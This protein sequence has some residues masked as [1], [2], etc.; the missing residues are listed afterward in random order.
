MKTNLVNSEPSLLG[1]NTRAIFPF[2]LNPS[3]SLLIEGSFLL[4][5]QKI[6]D[7]KI[8]RICRIKMANDEGRN[9]IL[10]ALL[11]SCS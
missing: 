8:M 11:G 10:Y 4:Y 9:I 3:L 5:K 1:K 7:M 6:K 2:M